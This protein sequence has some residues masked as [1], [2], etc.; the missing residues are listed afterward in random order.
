[1]RTYPLLEIIDATHD[2]GPFSAFPPRPLLPAVLLTSASVLPQFISQPFVVGDRVEIATSSG[3]VVL[4]GVVERIDPMRTI[5]RSDADVPM[6]IPNKVLAE[7]IIFNESRIGGN[8]VLSS[9]TRP[10]PCAV[11]LSL[12][13]QV[14]ALPR[15]APHLA[16]ASA[17][18]T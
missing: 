1:M 4:T 9:Y 11:T 6:T 13:Y 17:P 15:V 14:M 12:R 8:R 10:R 7:M 16:P 18:F 5:V 2:A 3:S